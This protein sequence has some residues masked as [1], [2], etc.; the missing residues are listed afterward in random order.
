MHSDD[1]VDLHRASGGCGIAEARRLLKKH[2]GDW[3]RAKREA[4]Q[5][6]KIALRRQAV[7]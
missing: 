4:E 5:G 6:V 3:H 2:D 7:A 1:I